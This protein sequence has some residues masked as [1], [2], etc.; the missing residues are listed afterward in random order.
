M[1]L[2]R[3]IIAHVVQD[4]PASLDGCFDCNQPHCTQGQW[5]ACKRRL[6]AV[7]ER[8]AEEDARL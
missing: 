7:A 5:E 8:K 3:A 2:I 6:A 1:N 4:V